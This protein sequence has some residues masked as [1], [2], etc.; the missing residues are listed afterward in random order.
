MANVYPSWRHHPSGEKIVVK[1]AQ[2][3]DQ[4]LQLDPHWDDVPFN[5]AEQAKFATNPEA[6][7]A[8]ID[9]RNAQKPTPTVQAALEATLDPT[10]AGPVFPSWRYHPSGKK[11]VVKTEED[12]YEL[13]DSDAN[14]QDTPFSEAEQAQYVEWLGTQKTDEELEQEEVEKAN[15]AVAELQELARKEAAAKTQKDAAEEADKQVQQAEA[16]QAKAQEA[17]AKEAAANAE[18]KTVTLGQSSIENG[19]KGKGGK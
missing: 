3:E 10:K 16:Q 14:W 1:S 2:H 13:T 18:E 9:K 5:E 11:L 4:L 15:N 7:K 12:W 19:K 6:F 17:A 8:Y